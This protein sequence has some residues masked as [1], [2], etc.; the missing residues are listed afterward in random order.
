LSQQPPD[1][2]TGPPE[3][4]GPPG[5]QPPPPPPPAEGQGWSQQSPG[6]PYGP[7]TGQQGQGWGQGPFTAVQPPQKRSKGRTFAIGCLSILPLF[8][9]VGIAT[10]LFGGGDDGG[11]GTATDDR[12]ETTSGTR[13]TEAP[14]TQGRVIYGYSG[15]TA[16]YPVGTKADTS[17]IVDVA[18][19]DP[20]TVAVVTVT[21]KGAV[22]QVNGRRLREVRVSAE[23]IA[24]ANRPI[25]AVL[26]R[27]TQPVDQTGAPTGPP[28]DGMAVGGRYLIRVNA[29]NTLG[30]NGATSLRVSGDTVD[31]SA[32]RDVPGVDDVDGGSR[33][34]VSLSKLKEKA[35]QLHP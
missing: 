34:T 13:T 4:W 35:K 2:P 29:D 18:P 28:L 22:R 21:G 14:A 20:Q 26:V 1:R 25:T 27:A 16:C 32:V 19:S 9:V 7:P 10:A 8:V 6:Q 24:G 3:G 31:T 33:A 17:Q 12:T 30:G 23:R 11:S 5:S 15:S